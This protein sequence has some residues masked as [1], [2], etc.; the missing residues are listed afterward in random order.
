MNAKTVRRQLSRRIRSSRNDN[1]NSNKNNNN[2]NKNRTVRN[3]VPSIIKLKL[4]MVDALTKNE[5]IQIDRLIKNTFEN[6]GLNQMDGATNKCI[7]AQMG[8]TIVSVLFLKSIMLPG[9]TSKECIYIH[10]VSVSDAHRGM[11]LLHKML[12]ALGSISHFKHAIFKLEAA[13]TN[14]H[15]LNQAAR[16]QIYSK[17]GFMLPRGTVVEPPGYKVLDVHMQV[18]NPRQSR[19]KTSKAVSSIK[20]ANSNSS[21]SIIYTVLDSSGNEKR[22]SYQDIQPTTC[23]MD[24]IKQ[25]RGC[26]MES[27]SKKLRDFN[28][29]K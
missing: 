5:A 10:T 1:N 14:D 9:S 15:G 21:K 17:S 2:N 24:G 3:R 26:V 18:S 19:S 7:F 13:N 8:K 28:A 29:S 6:A 22:V 4:K 20:H 11:G 16:F 27:D 12:N 25:E 23:Y